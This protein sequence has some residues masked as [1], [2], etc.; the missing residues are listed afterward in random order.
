MFLHKYV[1]DGKKFYLVSESP[2]GITGAITLSAKDWSGRSTGAHVE[3]VLD[4]IASMGFSKED[5]EDKEEAPKEE[6]K[7]PE[8]DE[9]KAAIVASLDQLAEEIQSQDPLVALALDQISD[10]LSQ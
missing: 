6:K 3:S 7:A 2:S 5:A 8:K 1:S 9:K 4:H 10:K